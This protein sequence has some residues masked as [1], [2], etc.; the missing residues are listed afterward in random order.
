MLPAA[1]TAF[2]GLLNVGQRRSDHG[3]ERDW[4]QLGGRKTRSYGQLT[5]GLTT[6]TELQPR[7][8]YSSDMT[9]VRGYLTRLTSAGRA[10]GDTSRASG[11]LVTIATSAAA[12]AEHRSEER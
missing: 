11:P 12:Q 10:S 4:L 1:Q 8:E 5:S 6:H 2:D 7:S 9:V 3:S